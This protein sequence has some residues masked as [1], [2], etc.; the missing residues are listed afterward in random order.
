MIDYGEVYTQLHRR[1]DNIFSGR[2]ITPHIDAI[3]ELVKSSGAKTLL[4]YG[5]GKGHQYHVDGV[6]QGWGGIQPHLFDVGVPEYAQRPHGRFDGVICTD[7]MEHIAIEDVKS[8]LKDVFRYSRQWVFFS[9]CIRPA[10]KEFDDG[11][12]VHL[13]V[14]P[15]YWWERKIEKAAKGRPYQVVFVK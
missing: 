9:I 3:A 10:H 7:V 4:D 15:S 6:H 1:T 2:S 12:N 5:C 11:T 13:S 14:K 8:V